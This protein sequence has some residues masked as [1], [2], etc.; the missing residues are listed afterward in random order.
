MITLEQLDRL[1]DVGYEVETT[2][3]L[4]QIIPTFDDIY[5]QIY[6]I[7]MHERWWFL[8]IDTLT[9]SYQCDK[10]YLH[11]YNQPDLQVKIEN[12]SITEALVELF[13]RLQKYEYTT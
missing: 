12:H 9:I 6:G 4:T 8:R 10:D 2:T 13:I 3:I 1:K 11:N 5:R 7:Y